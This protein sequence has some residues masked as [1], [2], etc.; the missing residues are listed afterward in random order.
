[1]DQIS[2]QNPRF[3]Q[4]IL[5]QSKSNIMRLTLDSE[6]WD[7]PLMSFVRRIV[8]GFSRGGA[9]R[10]IVFFGLGMVL[11]KSLGFLLIPI[12]TRFLSVADYG[13]LALLVIT[14]QL[15][16]FI[17]LFGISTASMRYYF[18]HDADPSSRRRER[19]PGLRS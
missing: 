6:D 15:L 17:F 18:D 12:Y 10:D 1:M 13:A 9:A 2:R 8:V 3:R 7:S 14:L 5:P 4:T 19:S 16:S 11:V